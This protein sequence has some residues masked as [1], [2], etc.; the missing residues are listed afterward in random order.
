[1]RQPTENAPAQARAFQ[2]GLFDLDGVITASA[3]VHAAAWKQLFDELLRDI[4][5][6]RGRPFEDDDYHRHVDGRPR[7]EGIRAF[8]AARDIRL[9]EGSADDPPGCSSVQA[10]AR[11]KNE[12]FRQRLARQGV[13]VCPDAVEFIRRLRRAGARAAMVSSSR[14]A[15]AVLE[16]A[17]LTDLFDLRVDG[18]TAERLG[19]RGKPAP[20]LFRYAAEKLGV[21]P[22]QAF[23]VEDAAAGVDA[24]RAAG[25]GLVVGI[26]HAGQAGALRAHGA[27]RVVRALG[28]LDLALAP[29]PLP[30]A[31]ARFDD[32]ARRLE[33]R[34][35]AVFLDYDGT[36]TPIVSRPEQARLAPAMREAVRAL[37][38]RCPVAVVSGRDRADVQRL[39]RLDDLIYAGSHGFDITGPGG[40]ELHQTAADAAL[41]ALTQAEAALREALAGIDGALVERKRFALA[42]HYRL[43]APE[44]VAAVEAAVARAHAESADA[45]RRTGG[46]LIFELRPN[47]PWD[48]GR[49][50]EWLLRALALDGPEVLPIYIGDDETDEDA[51]AAVR[52][53]GGLGVLVADSP[54][55]TAARFTLTD[56][57]AVGEFLRALARALPQ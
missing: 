6:D 3:R 45:L 8:L 44:R 57:P 9:P 7:E 55:P 51:F 17:G 33:G 5:G 24:A 41:P 46:K 18:I 42:V 34:R 23:A 49:A 22:A 20:D 50:V 4:P 35:A 32:I 11:R 16:A 31:L 40:L 56:P 48:K 28:E 53:H 1:M 15:E 38:R 27:Q 30:D 36:L 43:V 37:A 2:A 13:E 54:Q 19:L 29:T 39:V 10:L 52:N 25:V 12:L 47:L 21:A 26:D 14:N